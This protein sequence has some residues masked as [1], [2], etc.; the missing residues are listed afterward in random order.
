MIFPPPAACP[1]A[2]KCVKQATKQVP[3]ARAQLNVVV[4]MGLWGYRSRTAGVSNFARRMNT[5]GGAIFG[6]KFNISGPAGFLPADWGCDPKRSW[7]AMQRPGA[8]PLWK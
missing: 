6:F 1:K 8:L 4:F 3:I 2:N 5:I 7:L